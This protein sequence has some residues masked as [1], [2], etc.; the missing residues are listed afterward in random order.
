MTARWACPTELKVRTNIPAKAKHDFM[1]PIGATHTPDGQAHQP[2]RDRFSRDEA[3]TMLDC[4]RPIMF[5]VFF[6]YS[7]KD[8]EVVSPIRDSVQAMGSP[9]FLAEYSVK[10]GQSLPERIDRAIRSCDVFVLFWSQNAKDSAWVPQEIGLAHGAKRRIV[11]VKMHQGIDLPGFI[12]NR[13]YE[14]LYEDPARATY[15]IKKR[16]AEIGNAKQANEGLVGVALFLA[17]LGALGRG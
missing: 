9:V 5:N 2:S 3:P 4:W 16:I 10:P 14:K 1:P 8:L 6:S 7:T 17:M 12:Q 13:R 11:P 15:R